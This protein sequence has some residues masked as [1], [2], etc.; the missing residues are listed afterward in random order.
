MVFI[1]IGLFLW[2][3]ILSDSPMGGVPKAPHGMWTLTSHQLALCLFQYANDNEGRYP[4]GKNSVEVCQKLIDGKYL[5]NPA[6]FYL[7][8]KGKT[9]PLAGQPL[10]PENVCWDFTIRSDGSG[11]DASDPDSIPVVFLTGYKINYVAGGTALPVLK[12]YPAFVYDDG[13]WS[14]WWRGH[15]DPSPGLAVAYKSNGAKFIFL[16]SKGIAPNVMPTDFAAN[17]NRYRQLTPN[18]PLP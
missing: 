2:S 1:L 17:S 18:G 11:L 16:D 4:R 5:S 15:P 3:L 8:L 13:S 14:P 6:I 9:K 7:P 12:P 10:K